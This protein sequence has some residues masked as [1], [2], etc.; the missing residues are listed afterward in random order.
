MRPIRRH[1]PISVSI[2]SNIEGFTAP[3]CIVN[4]NQSELVADMM[5]YLGKISD[6]SYEKAKQKWNYV[7][8]ELEKAKKHYQAEDGDPED[9]TEAKSRS[10]NTVK[11]LYN[12][13]DHYCRQL[14]TL[15]F[16]CSHYDLNLIKNHLIPWLKNDKR[17]KPDNTDLEDALNM[18]D[19]AMLPDE[20]NTEQEEDV[21]INAI[22]KGSN[23]TQIATYRFKFLDISNYLAGGVS[24]AKFLKAYSVE[25]NKSY[26]PYEWFDSTDKLHHP[27][28]P[29]LE[30]FYSEL[31]KQNTLGDNEEAQKNYEEL[32]RIWIRHG[33]TSFKDF[34]VYY[35]NLDVGPFVTAVTRMQAFYFE[36]NIDLFKVAVSVPGIARRMLFDSALKT[37]SS[38]SLIH[39]DDDDLYYT[40]KKNIV[41]GPSI[42]FTREAEVDKTHINQDLSKPCKNIVGFDANA[43]YLW[44]I[45]QEMPCGSYIRR[46]APHFKAE[47]STSHDDMY[48]WMDYLKKTQNINILHKRNHGT[49]IRVGPYYVDGYDP[50]TK[51]VY[52]FNGCHWHGCVKCGKDQ[53]ETGM[54]RKKRTEERENFI[55]KSEEVRELVVIWEHEFKERQKKSSDSY[56]PCLVKFIKER[57]P[58]FYS[59]HTYDRPSEEKI[60]SAVMKNELFG[61]LEVDLYVPEHLYSTFKEMS[62]IFCNAEIQFKDIGPFMQNYV[63]ENQLSEKPRRLLVGGMAAEKILLSSPLLAWYVK[64]GLKV[65]KIH[66]VIEYTPRRC[67]KN[68]VNEVSDARRAGDTSPDQAIIA[69]TMKLIGNS[70]YGSLIMDKE[71]HQDVTYIEGKGGAYLAFN[72]PQFRKA[73]LINENLYEV[74]SAKG[75]IVMDLPIQLGYHILQL[76][77]LRMLQFKYDFLDQ[78]CLTNTFEYVEMDTDSAYMAI[79]GKTLDDIIK[80]NK[81]HLLYQ[82]KFG[83]CHH[84]SFSAEDGFFPR[85]CCAPHKAYDKRTPGLF[86][87]EAEGTAMIALCSKTYVLKQGDKAKFSSK[88]INK[89]ALKDVYKT[90]KTVLESK[91]PQSATNQGFRPKHGT[92]FT[93]EEKRQGLS[94][95]YCKRIIENDGVHTSPLPIVLSPWKKK[96]FDIVDATHLWSLT[97]PRNLQIEGKT[98]QTIQA[99]CQE[100]ENREDSK[101][102]VKKC[103]TQL[104]PYHPTGILLVPLTKQLKKGGW[105]KESY[106]STGVS[107]RA[108]PLRESLPGQNVMGR[109][110]YETLVLPLKDHDYINE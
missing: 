67:F 37:G 18:D 60:L 41:G 26:F 102:F 3:R 42:I 58:T 29:P 47:H 93:Y 23:Y 104:P 98:Y 73:S 62:P 14:P 45:G 57:Q 36:K 86:K 10:L 5:E 56:D 79:A 11:A 89:T 88:G 109:L 87:V 32:E 25:E 39:R 53:N 85:E 6:T 106:W 110:F 17:P 90:F 81:L 13:F 74:E 103:F 99:V 92:I 20:D 34:L 84:Q 77:K 83:N 15:G 75:K 82:Q 78:Y 31:K 38:F 105:D 108:S 94:Y 43:L 97:S 40:I 68:F 7:F 44:A 71:K 64:H 35:N 27:T 30:A 9:V 8:N 22:K 101:E 16:N 76:A 48:H 28:L 4:A 69:D 49:E 1:E 19:T 33:M 54:A 63:K 91:Q 72:N 80:P 12:S 70:G 65:A 107:S 100:A 61:F 2:C 21:K 51:T 46:H 24:Y 59:K 50:N 55:R 95:F 52:E 66:Q 96:T